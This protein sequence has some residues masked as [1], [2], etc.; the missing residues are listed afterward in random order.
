MV[1]ALQ[2]LVEHAVGEP[3]LR[4]YALSV[5][6]AAQDHPAHREFCELG[7]KPWVVALLF[8]DKRPQEGVQVDDCGAVGFVEQVVVVNAVADAAGSALPFVEDQADGGCFGGGEFVLAGP[9]F[10]RDVVAVS[11]GLHEDDPGVVDLLGSFVAGFEV[12][13]VF[14]S[15]GLPLLS[16]PDNGDDR[17]KPHGHQG[18]VFEQVGDHC[19]HSVSL[20][21][22]HIRKRGH[23]APLGKHLVA[24]YQPSRPQSSS[25]DTGAGALLIVIIALPP[26]SLGPQIFGEVHGEKSIPFASLWRIR[27]CL[28]SRKVPLNITWMRIIHWVLPLSQYCFFVQACAVTRKVQKGISA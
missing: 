4:I 7:V 2:V 8:G 1:L 3:Q 15:G 20:S 12:D 17:C 19:F 24:D 28:S 26:I 13:G 16:D 18:G 21:M 9:A 10:Y 5:F 25:R 6:V 11:N 27:Q 14:F 23:Q 22:N